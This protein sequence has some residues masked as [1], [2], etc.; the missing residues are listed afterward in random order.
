MVDPHSFLTTHHYFA[1]LVIGSSFCSFKNLKTER[2]VGMKKQHQK[3][4]RGEDNCKAKRLIAVI[5]SSFELRAKEV[6][7]N[8][9]ET[10]A[11]SVDPENS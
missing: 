4:T 2:C 1:I 7:L 5:E 8:T 6:D 3:N 10:I 9:L 11:Y